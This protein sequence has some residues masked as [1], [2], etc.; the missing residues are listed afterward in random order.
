VPQISYTVQAGIPNT[1]PSAV[2]GSFLSLCQSIVSKTLDKPNQINAISYTNKLRERKC[3]AN[4]HRKNKGRSQWP[5]GLRLRSAAERLLGSRVRIPPEAW[6][7]LS[8]TV[9]VLSGRGLCDGPIP[10]PEESYRLWCVAVWS[11]DLQKEE[12]STRLGPLRR[13]KGKK[14]CVDEP[15]K[16]EES[17][18]ET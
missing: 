3:K 12:A 7:F 2:I 1:H 10:R 18:R 15:P 14:Y 9:F 8:C 11:R 13:R 17:G 4:A 5:R 16:P 6:I